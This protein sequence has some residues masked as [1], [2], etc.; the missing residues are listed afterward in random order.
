[1]SNIIGEETTQLSARVDVKDF[2]HID[3]IRE[4][5]QKKSGILPQRSEVIRK[6][7]SLG[8]K[9]YENEK[10]AENAKNSPARDARKKADNGDGKEKRA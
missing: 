1:M 9:A 2:E 4:E 5:I 3:T 6:I 10:K 8:F 7:L